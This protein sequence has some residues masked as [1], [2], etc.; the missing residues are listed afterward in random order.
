MVTHDYDNTILFNEFTK[1]ALAPKDPERLTDSRYDNELINN[2]FDRLI[3]EE[4]KQKGFSLAE[5]SENTDLLISYN[6]SIR[7][8]IDMYNISKQMGFSYGSYR[9]YGGIGA[10][11]CTDIS[12]F[13]QGLLFID[14]RD[15]KTNQL[16][17]RGTGTDIVSIH[18]SADK[19][20]EHV[21][22]MVSAVLKSFPPKT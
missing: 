1:F 10:K 5:K 6:Y 12:E 20:S 11:T 3:A 21:T 22:E 4:L 15:A 17:W 16:L 14:I 2:R 18:A 19:I 9:R 7:P 13:D 8:K